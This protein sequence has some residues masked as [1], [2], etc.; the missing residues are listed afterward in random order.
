[1]LGNLL[2]FYNHERG[3]CMNFLK[4][5]EYLLYSHHMSRSD[6]GRAIDLAPSTINS[7]FNRSSDGVALKSLVKISEYFNISLDD[8]VNGDL[9]AAPASDN[10]LNEKEVAQVKRLLAYYEGLGGGKI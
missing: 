10:K 8:L 9:A 2:T 5:L 7:W 1:M 4:N 3:V 6:L